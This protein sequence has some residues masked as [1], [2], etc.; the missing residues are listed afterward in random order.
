MFNFRSDAEN[1]HLDAYCSFLFVVLCLDLANFN[2]KYRTRG[3]FMV[4]A[5]SQ[6]FFFLISTSVALDVIWPSESSAHQ[7]QNANTEIKNY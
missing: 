7:C 4:S 5:T 3:S 2:I 6:V 1:T